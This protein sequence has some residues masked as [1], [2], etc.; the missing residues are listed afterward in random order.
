MVAHAQ[1]MSIGRLRSPWHGQQSDST[2][3]ASGPFRRS[4]RDRQRL[5][6]G[7]D[8]KANHFASPLWAARLVNILATEL[9]VRCPPCDRLTIPQQYHV[10]MYVLHSTLIHLPCL[11]LLSILSFLCAPRRHCI[12]Y[13]HI[14]SRL[15]ASNPTQ[16]TL[17]V[18]CLCRHGREAG[19]VLLPCL[20]IFQ[21]PL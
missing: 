12:T 5:G 11:S 20:L 15:R 21:V 6:S 16:A 17:S 4:F 19:R 8:R 10:R 7:S 9:L 3:G 14:R 1:R 2:K 13:T 18:L